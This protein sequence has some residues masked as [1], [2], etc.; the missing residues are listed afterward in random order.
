MK[1]SKIKHEKPVN[2]HYLNGHFAFSNIKSWRKKCPY[3]SVFSQ[4]PRYYHF[5]IWSSQSAIVQG[6]KCIYRCPWA[7]NQKIVDTLLTKRLNKRKCPKY[8][9]LWS[10]GQDI[11][12]FTYVFWTDPFDIYLLLKLNKISKISNLPWMIERTQPPMHQ[13][14]E[15]P[16]LG[17]WPT[18]KKKIGH[19]LSVNC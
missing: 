4:E 7:I 6:R 16:Y 15:W 11:G 3:S 19:F 1:A 8:F 10:R 2:G 5:I 9:D 12:I 14:M 18:N 13:K 17:S